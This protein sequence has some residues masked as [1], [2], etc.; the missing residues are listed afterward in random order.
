MDSDEP[1]RDA[2]VNDTVLPEPT[3]LF[4]YCATR[5]VSASREGIPASALATLTSVRAEVS[6]MEI[7]VV[8]S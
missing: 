7:V 5:P 8:E 2:E 6:V 1:V 4:A 3:V